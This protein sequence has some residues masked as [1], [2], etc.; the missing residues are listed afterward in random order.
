MKR[1]FTLADLPAAEYSFPVVGL[2][3]NKDLK[4]RRNYWYVTAPTVY[5]IFEEVILK[6]LKLVTDQRAATQVGI[7]AIILVGGFGQSTYLRERLEVHVGNSIP[8]LQPEN[9]WTAVVEGAVMKGLAQ[10]N[11]ERAAV[12]KVVDRKARKHYGF[13]L[14]VAYNN[15]VHAQLHDKTRWDGYNARWEVDVMQ[16]FIKR[17]RCTEPQ[18][19]PFP[20]IPIPSSLTLFFLSCRAIL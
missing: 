9:A 17:V 1:R 16:W 15:R 19:S 8:I 10:V 18:V 5:K 7:K 11:P 2:E 13:Q 20:D 12:M 3:D 4:I 6:I 14:S